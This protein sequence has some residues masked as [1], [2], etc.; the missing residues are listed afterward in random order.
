MSSNVFFIAIQMEEKHL[1][2]IVKSGAI[3]LQYKYDYV[4]C[5]STKKN[6]VM[7]RSD[8][9]FELILDLAEKEG[10][11]VTFK[12]SAKGTL[13]GGAIFFFFSLFMGP[14]GFILGGIF[15]GIFAYCRSA[16]YRPLQQ[17]IKEDIS[18]TE[19][20]M[21]VDK[22][23]NPVHF[24]FLGSFL[25]MKSILCDVIKAVDCFSKKTQGLVMS[26]FLSI[27]HLTTANGD[28]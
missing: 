19:K 1:P 25:T 3:I 4:V 15:G 26:Q 16:E 5:L 13:L 7:I 8:V 9:I 23:S 18:S 10:L 17:V 11:Q 6:I 20:E 22:D 2:W 27:T 21:I 14:I 24:H 28:T 12:N